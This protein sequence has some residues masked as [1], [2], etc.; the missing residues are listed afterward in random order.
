M[1]K[2]L[3]FAFFFSLTLGFHPES[4]AWGFHAHKTIN[5]Y[6]VFTLPSELFGFYKKNIDYITEHAVDPDKRRY[7]ILEEGPRHFIDIDH[8]G[9]YPFPELP[10]VWEKAVAKFS[11]DTLIEYGIV[12]WNT[13]KV[14]R[15]LVWAFSQKNVGRIL[16]LS[17]DLGHYIGDAHVP[18]HATKNYNGQFTNQEGIHG[19][20]ESRLP[21]L[22][23]ADYDFFVGKAE[24]IERPQEAIWNA[25]LGSA[26]LVD[27][28]FS[29]EK[30]TGKN[31]SP[32]AKYAF[33]TKGRTVVKQYSKAYSADFH[34][35]LGS[36]VEDRMRSSIVLLGS[37][38]YSAWVEGGQP[39][40]D[41]LAGIPEKE[42]AIADSAFRE[43]K[44]KGRI[45][46]D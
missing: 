32:Q 35:R 8:Y 13:Y 27:T 28:V 38:W 17:A 39:N 10:R 42:D 29:S 20:L 6:A 23:A 19:L 41:Q 34:A 45:E 24:Y 26:K 18:L 33:E 40:L 25:V 1:K 43:G 14:Y 12:P 36:M 46:A 3:L 2:G 16:K 5:R 21:E 11:E 31:V 7:A 4:N 37:L 9:S 44:I 15:Q 22:F 30:M